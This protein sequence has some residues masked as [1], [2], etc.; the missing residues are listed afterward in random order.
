MLN[1]KAA[2]NAMALA[3][4]LAFSAGVFAKDLKIDF[5]FYDSPKTQGKKFAEA[6]HPGDQITRIDLDGKIFDLFGEWTVLKAGYTPSEINVIGSGPNEEYAIGEAVLVRPGKPQPGDALFLGV[7]LGPPRAGVWQMKTNEVCLASPDALSQ[8]IDK[9]GDKRESC[10]RVMYQTMP[11]GTKNSASDAAAGNTP[12]AT[13]EKVMVTQLIELSGAE[14]VLM[15]RM[16]A[17]AGQSAD[18]MSQWANNVRTSIRNAYGW[19]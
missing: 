12:P 3:G 1:F 11:S 4:L 8:S 5:N 6:F 15:Q 13:Q 17:A 14:R 10:Q 9:A 7:Y 16:S 19:K 2:A 18:A